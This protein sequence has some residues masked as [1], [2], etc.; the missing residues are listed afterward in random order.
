MMVGM[1]RDGDGYITWEEFIAAATDK[2]ALLNDANL[3]AAFAVLDEDG[4]GRIT[5]KELKG[6]SRL[7]RMTMMTR[8]GR[9]S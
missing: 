7:I 3:K 1:D 5:T 8:C 9:K 6:S 2:I 4:N